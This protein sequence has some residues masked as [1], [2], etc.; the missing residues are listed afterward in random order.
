MKNLQQLKSELTKLLGII[1]YELSDSELKELVRLL[2]SIPRSER[3]KY[4][5]QQVVKSVTGAEQF[6][7]KESFDNSDIDNIIDQIEDVLSK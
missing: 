6:I 3:T 2:K 5:I 4:R 1:G 7:I